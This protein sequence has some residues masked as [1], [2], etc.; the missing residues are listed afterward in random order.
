MDKLDQARKIIDR[1]DSEMAELFCRRMEAAGMIAAYKQERGLPI[2]DAARER[3]VVER[4]AAAITDEA[5]RGYYVTF[6]K[7]MMDLSKQYQHRLMDGLHVAYSGVEGAFADIAARRIFPDGRHTGFESFQAAYDAV[8]DG[9]CDCAVLPVENSY[10]GAVGQV[11]D[12]MFGGELYI[13]GVYTLPIT[14]N[15]LGVPGASISSVKTV[16]SH[17]QALSQCAGYIRTHG[18][19]TVAAANTAVAAQQVADSG[20]V[21]VAAIASAE[22]ARLYG[23]ELLDHDI[24]ESLTN[25]TKFAV[26][27]RVEN[28]VKD[29]TDQ[30]FI[31]LFTVNDV[32][33]ALAKAISV[34][35]G[36]GFNM[37]VLRS[38]PVKDRAWQYY[39]YVEAEGDDSSEEGQRML[40][41]LSAQCEKLKVAGHYTVEINLKDSEKL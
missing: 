24:N 6:L 10:A 22:T 1:V 34:I 13:N 5:L 3:A 12:L 31:L 7:G 20:D 30:K 35:A 21:A 15:L 26:F 36:H 9:R 40:E 11:M 25:T 32:A 8:A 2:F 29:K 4:N 37:K 19:E 33:G 18:Y 39:F 14:Q 27:S 17:P 38:R 16:I 28:R 41:D 23:L